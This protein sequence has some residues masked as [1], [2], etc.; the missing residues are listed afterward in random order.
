[1]KKKEDAGNMVKQALS[2][3]G[4]HQ[5]LDNSVVPGMK[6]QEHTNGSL[7]HHQS[8]SPS[9]TAEPI[10]NGFISQDGSGKNET[11]MSSE[12]ITSCVAT[13][14]MIQVN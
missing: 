4:E 13:W 6:H 8:R 3:L 9:K 10:T 7:D 14:L 1:M 5:P 12:L 2:S 11:K